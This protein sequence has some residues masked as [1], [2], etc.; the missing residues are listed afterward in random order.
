MPLNK[1]NKPNFFTKLLEI[2]HWTISTSYNNIKTIIGKQE[3]PRGV[4]PNV[5]DYDIVISGFEFQ[6]RYYVYF[7]IITLGKGLIPPPSYELNS[8][9]TVFLQEWLWH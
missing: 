8:P 4:V 1:E 9:I 3:N 6:S 7:R 5:L 2:F